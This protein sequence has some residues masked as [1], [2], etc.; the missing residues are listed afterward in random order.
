M[1]AHPTV[2]EAPSSAGPEATVA[3]TPD[4]DAAV[5]ETALPEA[6]DSEPDPEPPVAVEAPAEYL[7]VR[8][9][10]PLHGFIA[11]G[12]LVLA[13]GFTFAAADADGAGAT[14]RWL[15]AAGFGGLALI[16]I[17]S[18]LSGPLFVADGTGIRM[19][20]KDDWVGARWTEID[21]VTV[22]PRRHRLDDGRIAIHL[23]DPAPVLAALSS[24]VRRQTD[25]N[26]RLTG[27]SLAVPFG[28]AARPSSADV[29]GVLRGLAGE[30]CSVTVQP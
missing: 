15:A 8:A 27:S 1:T 14:A 11:I 24:T 4:T 23:A 13:V 26:R 20:I 18:I 17:R 12:A 10:Y 28:L 16:A 30:R 7:L 19:R 25:A 22:L 29:A 3:D 6:P 9:S 2:T 5:P 21:S